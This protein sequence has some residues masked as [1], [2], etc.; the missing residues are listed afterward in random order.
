M[1]KVVRGPP[2]R[3]PVFPTPQFHLKGSL[4][5]CHQAIGIPGP[6]SG[7]RRHRCCKQRLCIDPGCRSHL[8][9]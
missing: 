5:P 2:P 8:W 3:G 7:P 4:D 9:G 1:K 6:A